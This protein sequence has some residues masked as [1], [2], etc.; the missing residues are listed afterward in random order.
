MPVILDEESYPLWLDPEFSAPVPLL[1]LLKP[2]PA[3]EMRRE[4][5]GSRVNNVRHDDPACIHP[6]R[7]LFE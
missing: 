3:E 5:V 6:E 1:E 4:R 2:F 7:S